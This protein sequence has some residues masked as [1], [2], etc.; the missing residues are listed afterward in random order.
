MHSKSLSVE[1]K[2]KSQSPFKVDW[3]VLSDNPFVASLR[4]YLRNNVRVSD[5]PDFKAITSNMVTS[6]EEDCLLMCKLTS[7]SS[8]RELALCKLNLEINP[9]FTEF[10]ELVE[11]VDTIGDDEDIKLMPGESF[12]C[13]FKIKVKKLDA[14]ALR[15]LNYLF[16]QE[17]DPLK[18]L[19]E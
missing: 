7:L 14:E 13:L 8:Y 4:S 19:R 2:I 5:D 1:T 9:N 10:I 18:K 3:Q 6:S 12:D 17:E 16:G 11:R 15:N